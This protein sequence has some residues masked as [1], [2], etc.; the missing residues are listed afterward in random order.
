MAFTYSKVLDLFIGIDRAVAFPSLSTLHVAFCN[1]IETTKFQGVV[2]M[3]FSEYAPFRKLRLSYKLGNIVLY[4]Y[5]LYFY[6]GHQW[7]ARA[8]LGLQRSV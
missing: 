5:F 1:L 6:L 3:R 7:T 4:F 8:F 2:H